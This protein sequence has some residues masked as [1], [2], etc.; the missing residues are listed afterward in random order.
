MLKKSKR[1]PRGI[2]TICQG[3]DVS[4]GIRHPDK[5]SIR[6]RKLTAD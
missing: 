4:C 2:Q 1:L 6:R 3:Q 5:V